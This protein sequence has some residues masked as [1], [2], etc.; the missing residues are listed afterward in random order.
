MAADL[1][2]EQSGHSRTD[3]RRLW[4]RWGMLPGA[5]VR[6]ETRFVTA[7][8]LQRATILALVTISI[9]V[10]LDISANID[11]VIDAKPNS[12]QS[13]N[14]FHLVYY[15]LLRV[16]FVSPSVLLFA[17]VWG[18]V[19]A[20]YSLATSR[21]RLMLFNCGKS[22]VPSLVPALLVGS[23]VGILHFTVAG[24]V[25]PATIEL[26]SASTHRS[27]GLKFDRP[28]QSKTEWISVGNFIIKTRVEITDDAHL[29]EV[30][31]FNF[32][33]NHKLHRIIRADQARAG[34]QPDRWLFLD[35]AVT[36]FPTVRTESRPRPKMDET[37]FETLEIDL[38]LSPLW[39]ENFGVLPILLPQPLLHALIG[40]GE[41]VPNL[42]K[43]EMAAYERYASILYCMAMALLTAHLAMTRFK[44]DMMP[45]RALAVAAVGF[46]AYFFFS[47]SL[48][49]GHHG[50]I[51]VLI[52]AW[53][54]PLIAAVC[55]IVAVYAYV[56]KPAPAIDQLKL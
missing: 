31:V 1:S 40:Q 13:G 8:Y 17:G 11:N 25:K 23:L 44:S 53:S 24:F 50:Y 30:Y 10:A 55:G 22:Y 48:M 18:I 52:A 46:A 4:N 3:L 16:S 32:G 2:K 7:L 35:G 29:N 6:L 33:Q 19:W 47:I 9:V 5:L 20:E 41:S 12:S 15:A 28:A 54:L 51:P 37:R 43:Y 45:Y 38:P 21:E 26:E 34:S 42:Y 56:T 36:D 27:Y 39:L 14:F 49:L